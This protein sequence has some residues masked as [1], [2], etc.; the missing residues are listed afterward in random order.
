MGSG[1]Q[2]DCYNKARKILQEFDLHRDNLLTA[3]ANVQRVYQFS[4]EMFRASWRV[5]VGK[6]PQAGARFARAITGIR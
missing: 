1:R 6:R 5:W 3:A 4:G 2:N